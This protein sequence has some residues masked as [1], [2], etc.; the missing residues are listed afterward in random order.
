MAT[1]VYGA[2][3]WRLSKLLESG[4]EKVMRPITKRYGLTVTQAQLL[5]SV[6]KMGTGTVGS[7]AKA[8]GL[9]RTNTSSMCKKLAKMGFLKRRRAAEDE[10]VVS[11]ALTDTGQDA[12]RE[13]ELRLSH[14]YKKQEAVLGMAELERFMHVLSEDFSEEDEK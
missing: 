6:W 8:L 11:I 3:L 1:S 13:I 9:A 5:Y 10:R 2:S 7:I 14:A 12:V 4:L